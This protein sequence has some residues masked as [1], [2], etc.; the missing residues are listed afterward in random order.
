MAGSVS[1]PHRSAQSKPDLESRGSGPPGLD[2]RWAAAALLLA[3]LI[4]YLPAIRGGFIWDD[5][6][7]VT[8]NRTLRDME[9]LRRI[10]LD[11][12]A[13]PQY[14]PFVHTTFWLEYHLWGL[15]PGGYHL[16]NVLLHILNALLLGHVLSRLGV[17]GAWI[18]SF[19][20]ALHPVHVESVAW[21]TERKNLLSALFYLLALCAYL[22]Y[23]PLVAGKGGRQGSGYP[24][25]ASLLFFLLALLSK[26][27]AC[28]LPAAILL[29][30]WW[31]RERVTWRE[32]MSLAP[33]F[34]IGAA[35]GLLT[36]YLE[37][38]H[39]GAQ[40]AEWT[41]SPV[42]RILIAGRA[43]WFYASKLVWP[44]D[45]TFIYPRWQIDAGDPWQYVYPAGFAGLVLGLWLNR[46]R[47]GRAPLVAVLFFA[48]TLAPALGFFDVYPMLY[49][50]VADHFQY[51]ASASLLALAGTGLVRLVS[52]RG[53]VPAG[54][55]PAAAVL[56]VLGIQV[57]SRG[58]AFENLESL[59]TDTLRKSPESWMAHNNL[60]IV[61]A[62]S[63]RT[64][65]A[66]R[67]YRECLKIRPDYPDAHHNLGTALL[68]LDK[69]EEAIRELSEAV[70]LRPHFAEAHY[71]LALA[72]LRKENL[73]KASDQ[74]V[75]TTELQPGNAEA[76]HQLALTWSR[77]GRFDDAIREHLEVI[78]QRPDW[79]PPLNDLAWIRATHPDPS[80][81]DGREALR[82][83]QEA[84]R[85]TGD[86]DANVLD[87][88]A[89]AYA[90]L[91]EFERA[92]EVE[93]RA[94][95][96]AKANGQSDRVQDFGIRLQL[97]REG[98]PYRANVP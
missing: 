62:E 96:Q 42:D 90:E 77:L 4:A 3:T 40:G 51:L 73:Q 21:I 20:F 34:V 26:T 18:A 39:V 31:K 23:R 97:Y 16:V 72:F 10:W 58:G 1:K 37:K 2:R 54:Y 38:H 12:G 57:W 92:V 68:R 52:R 43:L 98:R 5:D 67:H 29:L 41:L 89:A 13:L 94:L 95:D 19:L 11:P 53:W 83:A 81:R 80:Y 36:L 64:A 8:E 63:G 17:S 14:Y 15:R 59:W 48:G 55:L 56:M 9:G 47:G 70:R 66:I 85:L 88:L 69:I 65:D 28:T 44:A 45:L 76:R 75:R 7:Y 74:L 93:T 32:V 86:G 22:R 84:V 27:I 46:H 79:G 6:A 24:Y 50:F 71:N 49:S 30:I 25:A 35:F 33:M 87:T 82:L 61:Y 60:G 91:G 78:R